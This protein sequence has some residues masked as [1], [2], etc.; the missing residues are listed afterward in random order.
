MIIV[1]QLN[2]I[3]RSGIGNLFQSVR[4]ILR[5]NAKLICRPR[6]RFGTAA[7]LIANL[8]YLIAL[9]IYIIFKRI[10]GGV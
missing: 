8:V 6:K 9:G 5:N 2:K 7:Q 1:I 10:V 4:G 3:N